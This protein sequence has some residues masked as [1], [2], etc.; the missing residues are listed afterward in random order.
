MNSWIATALEPSRAQYVGLNAQLLLPAA[1][2]PPDATHAVL[3]WYS[4]VVMLGPNG[5]P[6]VQDKDSKTPPP[7]IKVMKE[8]VVFRQPRQVQ[9][10]TVVEHGR[11]F[12]RYCIFPPSLCS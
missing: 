4:D 9:V 5:A 3:V 7:T 12:Y 8:V 1:K 10:Y 2:Y 6:L 11:R